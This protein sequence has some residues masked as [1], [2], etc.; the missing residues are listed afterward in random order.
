MFL[1]RVSRR[2]SRHAPGCRSSE[3]NP[4]NNVYFG[5]RHMHTWASPDAFAFGTCNEAYRFAIDLFSRKTR[6]I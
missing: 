6:S 1:R 2:A 4:L 5:E 3:P